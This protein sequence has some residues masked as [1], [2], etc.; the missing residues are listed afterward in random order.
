V[1]DLDPLLAR[2]D[3][4][5]FD[6]LRILTFLTLASQDLDQLLFFYPYLRSPFNYNCSDDPHEQGR[7]PYTPGHDGAG[8]WDKEEAYQ[9]SLRKAQ[10]AA[11]GE[12]GG[13][14]DGG[15]DGGGDNGGSGGGSGNSAAGSEQA[16]DA[17]GGGAAEQAR[18]AEASGQA[19][20]AS[21][22]GVRRGEESGS[23]A[24]QTQT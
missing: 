11:A 6:S 17:A 19:A 8:D 4:G 7:A 5:G 22:R 18:G 2:P 23:I 14:P 13:E 1:Q 3:L 9:A 12:P 24:A 16:G 20:D 15:G 21:A 10:Q